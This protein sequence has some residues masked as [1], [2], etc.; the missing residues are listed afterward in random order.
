MAKGRWLIA[1]A[2]ALALALPLAAFRQAPV[3]DPH[4]G[5]FTS[6]TGLSCAYC[7]DTKRPRAESMRAAAARM[8]SMVV[9]LDNGAL[10]N[11]RGI[12]C[13]SCHRGGGPEHHMLH[14]QPLDRALVRLRMEQW[15]G[16]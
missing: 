13:V 1:G 14:P 12:D 8:A 6:G 4:G 3:K 9:G 15:P 2:T 5:R 11:T 7:H 10:R 16:D